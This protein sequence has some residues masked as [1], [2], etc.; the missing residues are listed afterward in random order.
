VVP[1]ESQN[2][3]LR[4]LKED[5]KEIKASVKELAVATTTLALHSQRLDTVETRLTKLDLN[6]DDLWGEVHDIKTTCILREPVFKYGEKKMDHHEPSRDDWMN[7]LIG[8][9]LRNGIWIVATGVL[10]AL[11]LS[12]LG[13]KK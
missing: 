11:I 5:I 3:E 6:V 1:I 12:Y 13:V 8:S 7:I 10:T 4:D 9:A 2:V